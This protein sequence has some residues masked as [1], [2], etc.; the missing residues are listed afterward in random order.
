MNSTNASKSGVIRGDPIAIDISGHCVKNFYQHGVTSWNAGSNYAHY[1]KTWTAEQ[2]A[3]VISLLRTRRPQTVGVSFQF[4]E[5][6]I[7]AILAEA[8]LDLPIRRLTFSTLARMPYTRSRSAEEE[9]QIMA[10]I[11]RIVST[12]KHLREFWCDLGVERGAMALMIPGIMR[13][14]LRKVTMVGNM[15]APSFIELVDQN[16]TVR[17][18]VCSSGWVID[19]QLRAALINNWELRS[20]KS[21]DERAPHGTRFTYARAGG[22][23]LH[24]M[25]AAY[26]IPL[27]P[28]CLSGQLSAYVML[29]ILDWIELMSVRY[30]WRGDPEYDPFHGRKIALIEGLIRSYRKLH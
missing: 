17:E 15:D 9:T 25:L 5:Y 20:L 19:G 16:R 27:L 12:N 2:I 29:W 14:R 30:V 7:W 28:L 6:S 3:E 4:L 22:Y 11:A 24:E 21:Y 1:Q 26:A 18:L 23:G 8:L 13:S 10:D